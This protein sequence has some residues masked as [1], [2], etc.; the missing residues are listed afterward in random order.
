MDTLYLDPQTWDLALDVS[1]NI[2]LA[3]EPYSLA[4]DAA[5]ACRTFLGEVYYDTTQGI[6]YWQ[7]VLGHF[8]ALTLVKSQL[9]EAAMT[10]P[11]VVSAQMFIT[12]FVN[13]LYGQRQPRIAFEKYV[14]EDY[15]QHNPI[16]ADGRENALKWLEP[17]FSKPDA[18][19]QVRRVLVD[20]DFATIQIIGRMSAEDPG[21]AVMN[22][23]R[24]ENGIIIEHWDVTQAMPAQ[25]ASGRPLG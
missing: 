8:P 25:T 7:Q 24:L 10:V 14:H 18:E 2:A 5:S 12:D 11:G 21:S 16:I 1:R 20:G 13:L 6:P 4:Q 17:V 23:F 19:I 9:V 22:I 3:G 15:V